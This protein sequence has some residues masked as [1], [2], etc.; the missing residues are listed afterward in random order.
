[1]HPGVAQRIVLMVLRPQN[2]LEGKVSPSSHHTCGPQPLLKQV[3]VGTAATESQ[4]KKN[5]NNSKAGG[6]GIHRPIRTLF[7]S[8][9]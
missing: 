9:T 2:V 3:A 8:F 6:G 1:M 4:G 7:L 5:N